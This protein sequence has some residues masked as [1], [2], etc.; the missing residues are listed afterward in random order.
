MNIQVSIIIVNYNTKQMTSECIDSII[1]HSHDTKY[2]II[3]VDNGSLDGSKEYFSQLEEITYIYSE[4]NLGFGRANNLGADSAKGE[5]LFL[6]NSDTLLIENSIKKM[7]DFYTSK[8]KELNIGTLGCILVNKNIQFNGCGSSF[9]TSHEWIKIYKSSIPILKLFQNP[10][11]KNNFPLSTSFFQIDYVIGADIL[12]KK[13]IFDQVKGFDEAY[14]MYYEESD[15]QKRMYDLGYKAYITTN[16]SIIHLEDASGKSIRNYS[17]RK[18]IITHTSRN[19]YLKKNDFENF[20]E[21]KFYDKLFLFL[22]IINPKYTFREN[23]SYIKEIKKTY[24]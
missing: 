13:T 6:L 22:N 17:N 8:E 19:I 15:L 4:E 5:F 18:R 23:M 1:K 14:F 10:I 11:K 20:N 16:T 3:L 24:K 21:Y 9:P 2:E 12:I 7:F